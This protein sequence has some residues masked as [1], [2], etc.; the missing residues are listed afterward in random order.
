M[1]SNRKMYFIIA[2]VLF[3][4]R[5]VFLIPSLLSYGVGIDNIIHLATYVLF[6][7]AMFSQK[8]KLFGASAVIEAVRCAIMLIPSA[9]A[10]GGLCPV[11][12][13]W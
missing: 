11:C 2:G 12:F 7:T 13:R 6:A 5:F 8:K 4:I 3:V 10:L 1:K 9:P